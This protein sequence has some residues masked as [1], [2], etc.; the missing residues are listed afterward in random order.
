VCREALVHLL[1]VSLLN[2]VELRDQ[3]APFQ[4]RALGPTCHRQRCAAAPG[5]LTL[6]V[7][8]GVIGRGSLPVAHQ[9]AM[10][11]RV[12]RTRHVLG[13]ARGK[14]APCPKTDFLNR[15]EARPGSRL[16]SRRC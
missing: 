2:G 1:S 14:N 16:I 11:G 5:S 10:P 9:C 4:V 12:L 3:F 15:I 6:S 7:L 8:G 13:L